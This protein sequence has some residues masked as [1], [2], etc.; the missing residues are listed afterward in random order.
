MKNDLYFNL[1]TANQLF[2]EQDKEAIFPIDKA[3]VTRDNHIETKYG[4]GTVR[5]LST[6][7]TYLYQLLEAVLRNTEGVLLWKG[8]QLRGYFW[9][10]I[11]KPLKARDTKL[12]CGV[13]L[14]DRALPDVYSFEKNARLEGE[15]IAQRRY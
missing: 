4:I 14:A 3:K 15:K 13:R 8:N 9:K 10:N 5:N 7:K 11:P 1:H 6:G 2:T 12:A